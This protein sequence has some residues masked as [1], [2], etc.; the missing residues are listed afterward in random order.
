MLAVLV[1]IKSRNSEKRSNIVDI[2]NGD[3]LLTPVEGNVAGK[4]TFNIPR[5]RL[6]VIHDN[7]M[8]DTKIKVSY[9]G[10]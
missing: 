6:R 3:L 4:N 8:D 10:I 7:N 2:R 9:F 5:R 1:L